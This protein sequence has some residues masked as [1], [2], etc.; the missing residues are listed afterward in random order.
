MKKI[1]G[2][3]KEVFVENYIYE[4][5]YFNCSCYS[6]EHTICCTLDYDKENEECPSISIEMQIVNYNNIFSRIVQAFKYI[7]FKKSIGWNETVI[8]TPEEVE[9]FKEIIETFLVE[10]KRHENE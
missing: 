1:I 3:T 5:T 10:Y 2:T 6:K 9:K 7:F 4:T 8:D